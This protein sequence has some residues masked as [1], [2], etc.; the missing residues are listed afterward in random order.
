MN[1][2]LLEPKVKS[3]AP[4]IALMKWAKWCE[5]NGH[6]YQYVRGMVEP[7]IKPDTILMSCIFSYFSKKYE[8]TIDYYLKLFP[9]VKIIVG[10][11]FPTL[12]P[13]WFNKPKWNSN[14][15]F[16]SDKSVEIYSGIHPDIEELP[17]K[18]NVDILDEDEGKKSQYSR[19]KI[20]LYASRG[21]TNKCGYCAVPTLEGKMKSFPTIEGILEAG[22]K[23]LPNAKSVVLY[24]NNF[25]SH[26]YFDN[27]VDE[28]IDFGLP[29]DIHGLHV[30]S[31]TE[32]QA[33]RFS[34]LKWASQ[35]K[36]GTPYLRFSFDWVKYYK[37]VDRALSYVSKYNIKAAFFCYMLFNWKDTTHDFW[38]R[39]V[40][41][42][43]LCDKY[44]KTIFLFPQRFEPFMALHRNKYIGSDWSEDLVR[45]V[46]RMY[47][48]LHGFIPL[49]RTRNIFNWIGYTEEEF[50]ERAM[51]MA[52]N[53]KYR[54]EKKGEVP[55][56]TEELMKG[57]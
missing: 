57:I 17:P 56:L 35:G 9:G 44:G 33:K 13:E 47:T 37:H 34:E 18:Y 25:T 5:I 26:K 31:F 28:L 16:E 36:D 39:I 53:S 15:F 49:T 30:S 6:K 32:H 8:Q 12:M 55:P 45:G 52:R 46:T 54:L 21:C 10:G 1:Y 43:E 3:I 7:T 48:F 51:M 11:V 42:Q 27:I 14:P 40:L 2:L 38:K 22:K 41:S 20:V 4:N 29:I 19:D 50:I 24:D 23:D